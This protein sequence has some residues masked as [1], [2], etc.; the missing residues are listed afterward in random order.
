MKLTAILC[1]AAIVSGALMLPACQSSAM[2]KVP[3]NAAPVAS[4]IGSLTYRTSSD[5]TLYIVDKSWDKVVYSGP[6]KAGQTVAI[7]APNDQITID[8]RAAASYP[9][10]EGSEYR[11]FVDQGGMA[12]TD[13]STKTTSEQ[14]T[15]VTETHQQRLGSD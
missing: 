5:G 12:A 6:V 15:T 7:D 9:L 1:S 14:R 11:I 13:H 4:G 2:S 8:G 3:M 10:G